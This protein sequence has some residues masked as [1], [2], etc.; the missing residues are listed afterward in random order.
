MI[1]I[2]DKVFI[3]S[4]NNGRQGDFV[5]EQTEGIRSGYPW[6]ILFW[7]QDYIKGQCL[8]KYSGF[9]SALINGWPSPHTESGTQYTTCVVS[10]L[11]ACSGVLM[12]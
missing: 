8:G 7:I 12:K 4:M 5:F 11:Y 1:S 10:S 3:Y 9:C 6:N 2:I